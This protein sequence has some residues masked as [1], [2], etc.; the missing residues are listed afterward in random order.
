MANPNAVPLG[1]AATAIPALIV[2]MNEIKILE[3]YSDQTLEIAQKHASV[4][5]GNKSFTNQTPKIIS[6]LTPVDRHLNKYERLTPDGKQVIQE[7]ILSDYFAYHVMD[8]I[9]DDAH[10][11]IERQCE[12]YT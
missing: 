6:D 10:Q 12:L 3:V 11:V 1:L 2:Y 7:H 9:A 5:W 4:T 8:L